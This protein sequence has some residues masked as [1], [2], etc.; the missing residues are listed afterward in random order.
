MQD[1]YPK[2]TT[3]GVYEYNTITKQLHHRF[4]YS[5]AKLLNFTG[6][7]MIVDSPYTLLMAG[8]EINDATAGLYMES[9]E[10][11]GYIITPEINSKT[12]QDAMEAQYIKA[13]T[14]SDS[15]T[16]ELKYRVVK[17]DKQFFSYTLAK[18][19]VLNTTDDVTVEVGMK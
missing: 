6:P 13:K 3:S 4:C 14:L 12:I 18:V 9:A 15:D 7:L 17:K 16:I 19:N 8:S 11:F 10:Y 2:D 1:P 5:Q